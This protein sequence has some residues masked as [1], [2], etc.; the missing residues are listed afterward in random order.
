MLIYDRELV[1]AA[2]GTTLLEFIHDFLF[3]RAPC[4]ALES[5]SRAVL[6]VGL[7]NL[8]DFVGGLH[9][10]NAAGILQ[11]QRRLAVDQLLADAA[12]TR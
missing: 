6:D 7:G 4:F 3:G 2:F 11:R 12:R 5:S 1:H 8:G 10:L 9:Q